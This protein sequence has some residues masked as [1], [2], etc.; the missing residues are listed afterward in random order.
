ME[1]DGLLK[2]PSD[3]AL[4]KAN[5]LGGCEQ[6]GARPGSYHVGWN[7]SRELSAVGRPKTVL[8]WAG[9]GGHCVPPAWLLGRPL[10][11][12]AKR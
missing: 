1:S 6:L 4:E 2:Y 11:G 7:I 12:T 3:E 5:D 8:V 9:L 10:R